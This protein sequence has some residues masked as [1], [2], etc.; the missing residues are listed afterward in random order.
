MAVNLELIG[1]Q[2][3]LGTNTENA[4]KGNETVDVYILPC[5][6]VFFN[7]AF[8]ASDA[9]LNGLAIGMTH[10]RNRRATL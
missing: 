2:A 4:I 10:G 6:P 9:R 8:K 5:Q 3:I 7:Q 1:I